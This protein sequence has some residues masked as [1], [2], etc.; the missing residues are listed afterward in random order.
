MQIKFIQI[1]IPLLTL[2]SCREYE[3]VILNDYSNES[4]KISEKKIQHKDAVSDAKDST[5]IKAV[6]E[7][8]PPVK[9]GGHWKIKND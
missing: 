7:K 3:E 4:L 9:H 2:I 6:S 1:V 8:D 5:V